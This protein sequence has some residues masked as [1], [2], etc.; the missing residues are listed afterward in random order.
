MKTTQRIGMFVFSLSLIVL[1]AGSSADELKKSKDL[2]ILFT[3]DM[4]SYFLPH[5][6]LTREGNSLQQGGYAKLA[7]IINEQRA[8]H[9]NKTLLVDGGDFAMGTFFH[10]S[11]LKEAFELRLMGK[12]GYDAGTLGNHDFDFH[13]D[14][15]AKTLQTAKS[16]SKQL[17][18]LVASNVVFSKD[19]P[20]DASLKKA[21]QDYPVK[22]YTIIER[23]DLRIGLFGLLGKDAA[24]D[25][26]F[27]KPLTFADPIQTGKR[28]VDVLKNKEKVDV[29]IC[30]S[31][32]GTSPVRKDSE[33][34]EL[35]KEVPEIDVIISGH[36]HTIIPEPIVIGKTIIVSSGCYTEYLG[37]LG[38]NVTQ[39]KNAKLVSYQ[40]KKITADIPDDKA[41]AAEI[42]GYKKIIDRDFLSSNNLQFDQVIAESDFNMES[43]ASAY[44]DPREMGLGNLITDAYRQAIK[45]A[46]GNNYSY[47]HFAFDPLGLIRGSFPKGPITTADVFQVLSLGLGLDGSPGYPLT[48][49]YINGKEIKNILEVETTVAPSKKKGAHLQVSGVKFTFNPKRMFF[50]RVRSVL[51]QEEDGAYKPLDPKRLYRVGLNLYAAEMV[52]YISKVTYGILKVI[53]KDKDGRPF[54]DLKQTV[55]YKDKGTSKA[56]ELKEWIALVDYLRSFKD[57]NGNGLAKIPEKYRDPEGRY[58]SVSSLNPVD[59]VAGGNF[60]TYGVLM[61]GL[62]L[63]FI[64]FIF[65]R[66]VFRKIKSANSLES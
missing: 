45:K 24:D 48:A 30:L 2:M 36:T 66:I 22:E 49:C 58:K 57:T 20:G 10:T 37:M 18:A 21:F 65:I 3:H 62:L 63:L 54:T 14:G 4:H 29:I 27:A 16:K 26:P 59:L 32:S 60:L 64:L 38:L 25:T 50:D 9:N 39:G 42:A 12:I 31:H 33:D 53:P 15:L 5:R 13:N 1:I 34:E 7:Y 40:L 35:A 19:N 23:N 61:I 46:E 11:F 41:I 43:L 8:I 56:E 52:D 55:I 28:M 51:V 6:I 44:A 17:P 47:I